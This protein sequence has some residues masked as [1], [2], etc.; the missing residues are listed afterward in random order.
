MKSLFS[1]NRTMFIVVILL[2]CFTTSFA[3]TYEYST[4]FVEENGLSYDISN[5]NARLWHTEG[6]LFQDVVIPSTLENNNTVYSVT[7]LRKETFNNCKDIKSITIPVTVKVIY[8]KAVYNCP[9][10]ETI[11]LPEHFRNH[12]IKNIASKCPKLKNIIYSNSTLSLN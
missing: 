3:Q 9:N 5:G 11:V 8:P 12:D 10:L 1:K 4:P 7:E 2:S 6:V